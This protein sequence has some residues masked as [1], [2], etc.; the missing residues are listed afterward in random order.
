MRRVI[1]I[2]A[3]AAGMMAAY[4]AA[5][6]GADVTLLEQ[7]EKTGKKIYITGKGRCN[8]TNACATEELFDHVVRNGKF[9]YSAFYTFSN[10]MV[11]QFFEEAGC[12]L[13]TER[14]ERV[15]PVSDHASDVIRALGKKLKALSVTIRLH[16]CV[17][18]LLIEREEKGIKVSGVI[19]GN[20]ERL[21]A[22][23]VIIATGGLSYPSTGSTGDGYEFAKKCGHKV[24]ELMPSLVPLLTAGDTA[25]RLQGLS[26][27]NVR[28][29][30][31]FAGKKKEAFQGFGE[32]LFT[33]NGISGPLVLSAST[34]YE[35]Q[36][37]GCS[38]MIDLKPALTADQLDKR[39]IRDISENSNKQF[40]NILGGLLP[41]KMIPVIISMSGIPADKPANEITKEERLRLGALIKA[42]TLSVTGI[43]DFREAVITRGGVMTKEVD[44]ST[45]QSKLC[46]G[47][48]FAGEVLDLDAVT[49]GFN[50]QIAWSTGYLAGFFAG[51]GNE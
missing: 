29:K 2:G 27:K 24:T 23:A 26:L 14:G 10:E 25:A 38:F 20:N 31:L 22:D 47:L 18:D 51:T 43:G 46:K 16:S 33:Q 9:L 44:P 49:G 28:A 30:M 21:Q 6:S 36:N 19:L 13:K 1:I 3:G 37:N 39:L 40:K 48:Y 42:F 34:V 4:A 5:Q 32:M 12:P 7:N 41:A 15:F 45:M 8:L 11:M 17:K 35:P 50:L